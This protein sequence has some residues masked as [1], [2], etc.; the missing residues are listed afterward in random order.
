MRNININ[1]I[2]NYLCRC[3]PLVLIMMSALAITI[4]CWEI[5]LL[6]DDFLYGDYWPRTRA[7]HQIGAGVWTG[8]N[9][10]FGDLS[11][12]IWLHLLPRPITAILCGGMLLLAYLFLFKL[13]GV[14][15]GNYFKSLII[16]LITIMC[17][18]FEESFAYLVVQLNYT[19]AIAMAA[20]SLWLILY[21][22]LKSPMWYLAT[23]WVFASGFGHEAIGMPMMLGLIAWIYLRMPKEPIPTLKK[24]LIGVLFAGCIFSVS[25]P[26]LYHHFLYGLD[27]QT[28]TLSWINVL[29][30]G[31]LGWLLVGFILYKLIYRRKELKQLLHT[32]WIAFAVLS[33]CSIP[34]FIMGDADGR[35]G[36]GVQFFAL[37]AL[38]RMC[39]EGKI[40][41]SA[42]SRLVLSLL[43]GT[44]MFAQLSAVIY[45]Q[46]ILDAETS[47][48]LALYKASP[49][50]A[51]ECRYHSRDE[52]PWYVLERFPV[53]GL[54]LEW[55]CEVLGRCYGV[56]P[57]LKKI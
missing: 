22:K 32:P 40:K 23:P 55:N 43:L 12:Y 15:F 53:M 11:N 38:I 46:R 39:P 21:G 50:A 42:T 52:V 2:L 16:I 3:L 45:W 35:A 13:S 48:A 20:S 6:G 56:R 51:V 34:F 37:V 49:S 5:P 18:P 54:E 4:H 19:W 14:S 27:G 10:R 25:S 31:S 47:A 7:F 28:S 36:W 33:I 26:G 57:S 41:L 9:A 8:L 24:W 1:T 30:N 17:W 44:L 29:K